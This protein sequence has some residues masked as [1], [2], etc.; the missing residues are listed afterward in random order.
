[1][2]KLDAALRLQKRALD[3]VGELDSI[4]SDL[5]NEFSEEDVYLI[6]RGVGLSIGKIQTELL[7]PI[8]DQHPRN[9]VRHAI[10]ANFVIHNQLQLK[11]SSTPLNAF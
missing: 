6:N 2:V 10:C 8:Y 3:A 7:Q 11:Y 1:M 4:V 5:R 9:G